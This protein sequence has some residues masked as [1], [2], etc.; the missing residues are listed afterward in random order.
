MKR[1]GH[2]SADE[3][4]RLL[5]DSIAGYAIFMLGPDGAIESW[6]RGGERL[7]GYTD[8]EVIGRHFSLFFADEH[9]P[10]CEAELRRARETGR[11]EEE[12]WRLR[13][14]GGRFWAQA[15]LTAIRDETGDLIGFA[16]VTR[17]MSEQRASEQ[18]ARIGEERFRLMV[19]S[20]RD[21]AIFMLDAAGRVATWNAGAERIKGYRAEEI[22]GQ[23]FS[24]F[25]PRAD[26]ESGKPAFELRMVSRDGRFEDEGWRVRK[27]GTRFWANVIITALRDPK[28]GTLIGFAKVTRDLTDRRRTEDERLKLAQAEE[29][30]RLRDEF[31]SIASHELRTPLTALQLQ[32]QS[33]HMRIQQL[34]E[35]LASKVG[36]ATRSGERLADLIEALLD[37]SRIATGRFEL[38]KETFDIRIAAQEV[39][40]RLRESAAQARCEVTLTG[41]GALF[42]SWDRLRVE[43]VV[44]NL[45]SNA[46]KY[47][48]GGKIEVALARE[49][50]DAVLRVRDRGPGIP[51]V[52]LDRIFGR[53][54]R[55]VSMRHYGG[56][57]LGLYVTRQIVDAHG[58]SVS[59]ANAAG[60]GAEFI[61]RLPAL[62][63]LQADGPRGELN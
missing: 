62:A 50:S 38:Q 3:Q 44:T 32:L 9:R 18:Q 26:V 61:V 56:M 16:K 24:K 58:G 42:G 27:D 48:A 40:E 55:A 39:V 47:G 4:R 37:V 57:G 31:L 12:G 14:D 35:N 41:G 10:L 46:F 22:I 21:Y 28:D 13:K 51:P 49:G 34:D 23:H 17:D 8:D 33:L 52:D 59:A 45:L 60:G 7:F 1:E 30:I 5:L 25:Y 53:F 15:V 63:E 29:A 19:D 20:V 54:E 43:Q 2:W 36:R 6:N 11:A